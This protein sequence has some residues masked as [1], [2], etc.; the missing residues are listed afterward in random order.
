M[1]ESTA[2]SAGWR[3]YDKNLEKPQISQEAGTGQ[4][5]CFDI[6]DRNKHIHQFIFY[7]IN[8]HLVICTCVRPFSH[9]MSSGL[10]FTLINLFTLI[11]T[12]TDW[13]D[14]CVLDFYGPVF[15]KKKS[16][17]LVKG[18]SGDQ[19]DSDFCTFSVR[20]F[21]V[22]WTNINYMGKNSGNFSFFFSVLDDTWFS[23]I[24]THRDQSL[25]MIFDELQWTAVGK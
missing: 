10:Y 2:P 19:K 14:P 1:F 23:T 4:M 11:C 7:N 24:C 22:M 13:S 25:N 5:N 8:A 16:W 17:M 18:I 15:T 6:T 3:G 21:P 9:T 12:L 20:L